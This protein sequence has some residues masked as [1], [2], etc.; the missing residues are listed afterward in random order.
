MTKDKYLSVNALTTYIAEKFIKDPYLERVFV[1]GELS[2]AKL[3]SSG[4]LYFSLKDENSQIRGIM[5]QSN[6]S[7]LNFKPKDGDK[8][9]IEGRVSIYKGNGTYSINVTNMILDGVG[10]LFLE[11]E[12]N[13]KQLKSEGLF[14]AV[15]K[16]P[17][18]KFPNH[19]VLITSKTS[20]AIKDMLTAVERRYPLVKVTLLNTLM[21]GEKSKES[22]LRN[23]AYAESLKADTIIL[24]RGG[25]SIED[26]WT[27]NEIEVAR[28]VFDMETPVITGIGHET[29]TTLVDFV[30]DL[31]AT[32]PTAAIELAV[33]DQMN[34]FQDLKNYEATF[35]KLTN[36]IWLQ[37]SHELNT[38][39]NYY[40]FKNPASLY[41]QQ[42]QKLDQL[43]SKMEYLFNHNFRTFLYQYESKKV[44]LF[45]LINSNNI[46]AYR[47]HLSSID[48]NLTQSIKYKLE[49]N[50]MR[51]KGQI[52][53]LDSLSPLE[54][55]KRGYSYTTFNS[56]VLT[57]EDEVNKG[58]VVKTVLKKGTIWSKV[59]EVEENDKK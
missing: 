41:E 36:Q 21:Q 1:Q 2:N 16:K 37:K 7:K 24:S 4:H 20:A 40:K 35:L 29:D 50:K 19:I 51:L 55:L 49:N 57:K 5:F 47:N 28:R 58:D 11:L 59:I 15:H 8:V 52:E 42:I 18:A 3:H 6:V 53:V 25:G 31:R 38:V 23:L 9:I 30:S 56:R 13:I 44:T 12:K 54:V 45:N 14:E 27:F 39:K 46:R 22:V 34:V 26:L 48:S 17:I 32:T 10:Q 43:S 33:P